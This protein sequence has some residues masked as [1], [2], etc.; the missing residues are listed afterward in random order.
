MAREIGGYILIE[1]STFA[2]TDAFSGEW[3]NEAKQLKEEMEE[4]VIKFINHLIRNYDI[5][6]DKIE[7]KEEV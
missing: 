5:S 2:K 4:E 3:E 1:Y 6:F 7:V